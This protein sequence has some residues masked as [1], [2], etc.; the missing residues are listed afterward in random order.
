MSCISGLIPELHTISTTGTSFKI[1]AL[2]DL[3]DYWF[4]YS[5]NDSVYI[6]LCQVHTEDMQ[7]KA[8]ADL[9]KLVCDLYQVCMIIDMSFYIHCI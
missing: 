2:F 8:E 7:T 6:L 3:Q 5:V 1:L 4:L 9:I